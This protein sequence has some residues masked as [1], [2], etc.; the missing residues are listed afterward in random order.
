[1]GHLH[2]AVNETDLIKSLNLGRQSTVDA[3][4]FAFNDGTNAKV[5]EYLCAVLPWVYVTVLPHGL[6][7]K[8]VDAGYTACLVVSTKKSDAVR[9]FKLK[10][11]KELEC[12][13]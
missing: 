5:V 8:A 2:S 11:E 10:A 3:E 12:F 7:I 13:Y 1:M 6:F 9:V 4:N